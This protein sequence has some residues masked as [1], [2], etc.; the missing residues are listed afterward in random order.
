MDDGALYSPDK[1]HPVLALT[2]TFAASNYH[3]QVKLRQ[4]DPKESFGGLRT[5]A[6]DWVVYEV[7][8]KRQ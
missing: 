6:T 4:L 5:F 3:V 2:G 7:K 8:A 1:R